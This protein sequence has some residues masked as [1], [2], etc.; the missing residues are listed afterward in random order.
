MDNCN[1][2]RST[3]LNSDAKGKV[4]SYARQDIESWRG[5]SSINQR[6]LQTNGRHEFNTPTR[7]TEMNRSL[8]T[9]LTGLIPTLTGPIPPELVNMAASLLALSRQRVGALKPEEESAR[10]YLCAHI[11]CERC[12]TTSPS[13]PPL[14]KRQYNLLH[15]QFSN[16]LPASG[17]RP[18]SPT[19]KPPP[20]APR[21][22]RSAQRGPTLKQAPLTSSSDPISDLVVRLCTHR[23]LA[24][25]SNTIS[26]PAATV[27]KHVLAASKAIEL[28]PPM[29]PLDTINTMV[30][31]SAIYILTASK[32]SGKE[33]TGG[34]YIPGSRPNCV[35]PLK[36]S[37]LTGD[38]LPGW[39][40]HYHHLPRQNS[41][42]KLNPRLFQGKTYL[43]PLAMDLS[44]LKSSQTT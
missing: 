3:A 4:V 2:V 9:T 40:H 14:P 24:P 11:A 7:G 12:G 10:A 19:K 15:T 16:A 6:C 38:V 33:I 31:L 34:G 30:T 26:P 39:R 44:E 27:Y 20:A 18:Q 13:R 43:K 21:T 41:V 32:L 42:L 23:S 29:T 37:V 22:P 35:L 8:E 1:L 5:R 17:P 28:S 25:A 36:K